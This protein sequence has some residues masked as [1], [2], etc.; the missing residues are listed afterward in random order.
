MDG[1]GAPARSGAACAGV[2]D[3]GRSLE[4]RHV[5]ADRLSVGEFIA[6]YEQAQDYV[7]ARAR[8]AGL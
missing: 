8:E 1:G 4:M 7:V 2:Q 6:L 3:F 5:F